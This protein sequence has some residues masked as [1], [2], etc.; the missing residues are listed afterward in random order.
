MTPEDRL[1]ILSIVES[2]FQKYLFLFKDVLSEDE[3]A[4]Y[5]KIKEP[6]IRS[7]CSRR[8]ITFHKPGG[9]KYFLK[10]DLNDYALQNRI[11]SDSDLDSVAATHNFFKNKKAS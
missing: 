6:T 5:L 4:S 7:M 3:A 9:K 10:E 2:V 8:E 1:E 11:S